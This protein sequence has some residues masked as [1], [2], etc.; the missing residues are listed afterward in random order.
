MEEMR[1]NWRVD[2]GEG[3]EEL[4]GKCWRERVSYWKYGKDLI[5]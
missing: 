3:D 4:W 1:K 5:K 2:D